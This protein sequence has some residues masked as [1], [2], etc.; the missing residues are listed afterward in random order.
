[1]I[2]RTWFRRVRL[3]TCDTEVFHALR[4]LECNPEVAAGPAEDLTISIEPYRSHYRIVQDGQSARE[5]MSAEGVADSLHAEVMMLSLADFPAAPLIHAASLRRAGRRILLVGQK[6]GGKTTLTLRLIQEG[7][8]VEG[9]ENVFV[10]PEGVVAR[11][12]ALRVKDS[13]ASLFA[14]LT[15]PLK[16]APYYHSESNLRTYNLDPRDAGAEFWRIERGPVNA[17]VLLR[18]NHGGYSSLRPISS[19]PLLREVIAESAFPAIG[20]AEA[21]GVITKVIGNARGFDLS[22][23]DLDEAVV[24]LDRVFS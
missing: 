4:Y 8:E 6:G 19:L 1:V 11:P 20:R 23:G 12:R 13:T 15:E 7:Y 22:L 17:V 24:C 9:D 2:A 3:C 10:T 21:V 16:R 18:P 5:L 14:H